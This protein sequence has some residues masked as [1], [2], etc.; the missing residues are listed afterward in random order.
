VWAVLDPATFKSKG[1]ATLTKQPDG[2]ILAGGKNPF[3]ETY[4]VTANTNLTGITAIRL[5][6]LADPSLPA[7]GPGRANNGN[8]VL[9]EFT[10]TAG[11][12]ADLAKP[13]PV[14]LQNASA[15]FSQAGFAVGAAI[16]NNPATGWAILP[17]AGQSQTALFELAKPIEFFDGTT[18]KFTLQQ[19]YNGRNHN[20]GRFRLSVTTAPLPIR[21]STLPP[22]LKQILAVA[23]AQRT[24]E[25]QAVLVNYYR[26]TDKELARLQKAVADHIVPVNARAIGAQDLAWA[27]INSPAF[28]FNH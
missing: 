24:K 19:L 10:V 20:I 6:V 9:N 12:Q 3:P 7:K 28:L 22:Q 14:K 4:T 13:V 15:T 8:F 11:Q 17:M 23:P 26:S 16:D 21:V 1:G 18:L 25:Q 27:L 5:E 2:S